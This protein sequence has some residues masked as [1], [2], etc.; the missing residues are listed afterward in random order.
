[1]SAD[2]EDLTLAERAVGAVPCKARAFRLQHRQFR[3]SLVGYSAAPLEV[4]AAY[5]QLVEVTRH[6][7]GPYETETQT[8]RC[9]GEVVFTA[10]HS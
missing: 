4:E 6:R 3:L 7:G 5:A 10:D 1:M 9:C 2:V 8:C